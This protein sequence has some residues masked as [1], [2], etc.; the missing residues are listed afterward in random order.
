MNVDFSFQK[1]S[2]IVR[3][4][5]KNLNF[6]KCQADC[7]FGCHVTLNVAFVSGN[8]L[9]LSSVMFH[10]FPVN[11]TGDYKLEISLWLKPHEGSNPSL[12]AKAA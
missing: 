4:L 9:L 3:K 1:V 12:S 7:G 2:K 8:Y 6:K 10:Y 5:R 11:S